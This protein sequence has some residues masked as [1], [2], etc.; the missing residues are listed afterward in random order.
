[1]RLTVLHVRK[2]HLRVRCNIL[3]NFGSIRFFILT[4]SQKVRHRTDRIKITARYVYKFLDHA[5]D[6]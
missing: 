3:Q 1:M 4:K 6:K 2:I 5:Y